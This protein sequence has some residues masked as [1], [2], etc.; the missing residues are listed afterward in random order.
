M[1]ERCRAAAAMPSNLQMDRSVFPGEV[2]GPRLTEY[3]APSSF[4]R[5][6]SPGRSL[7]RAGRL[8]SHNATDKRR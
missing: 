4:V 5:L 8:K 3:L 1:P 6:L 7:V 2:S